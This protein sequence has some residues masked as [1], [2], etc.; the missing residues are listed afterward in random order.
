MA[1]RF[2]VKGDEYMSKLTLNTG[3]K[4]YDIEDENGKMLGTISIYP[5]DFNIGKRAMEV[6][7]KIVEYITSAEQIAVENDESAIEQ[8]TEIDNKIKEQLDYLFNSDV[9]KTVFSGL[10]CL[11]VTEDGRY[12]IE[13]FLEMIM[14]VINSELDKSLKASQKRVNKYTSQVSR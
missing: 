12:F 5:N 13:R 3:V 9:S 10:H 7:K 14:P 11:N 4:T 2:C 1:V 6:Q 8:I